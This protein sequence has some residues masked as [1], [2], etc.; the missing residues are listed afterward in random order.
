MVSSNKFGDDDDE[1]DYL[2]RTVSIRSG[3]SHFEPWAREL[4][5]RAR[6]QSG[7]HI[8]DLACGTGVVT[9]ELQTGSGT[10][11]TFRGRS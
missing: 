2:R 8:L 11:Q 10:V 6:P 1:A 9:K 5:R 7:E 3:P 4:I